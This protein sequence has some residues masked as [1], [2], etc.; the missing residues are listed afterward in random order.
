MSVGD[1]LRLFMIVVGLV[2]LGVTTISLARKHMTESFCIFWGIAS[3]LLIV[4]GILLR[5]VYLDNYISGSTLAVIFFGTFC[6]LVGGLY[7]SVRVSALIRQVT[8][9]AIQISLLNQENLVCVQRLDEH[10][11]Y[12]RYEES[13]EENNEKN[14][15]YN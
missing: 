15:I 11:H 13:N 2:T 7:F 14:I 8:E 1:W 10:S 5:P 4:A 12:V 3:F 6:L 9:L